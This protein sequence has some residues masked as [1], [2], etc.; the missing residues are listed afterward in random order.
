MKQKITNK[1]LY[2]LILPALTGVLFGLSALPLKVWYMGFIGFI[3]L[4]FASDWTITLKRPLLTFVFQLF[5]ATTIL[6]YNKISV[7]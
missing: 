1:V 5:I 6:L 4:L 7:I 2:I 3:S